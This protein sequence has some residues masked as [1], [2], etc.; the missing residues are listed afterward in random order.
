M[1]FATTGEGSTVWRRTQ[2][3]CSHLLSP[4]CLLSD[5]GQLQFEVGR[6]GQGMGDS[7]DIAPHIDGATLVATTG[8]VKPI[9]EPNVVV[10]ARQN[11]GQEL[12]LYNEI[13]P[14]RAK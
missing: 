12:L 9:S 1:Q 14:G 8:R 2:I 13:L 5:A 4:I 6:T 11:S 10:Q 3:M 7:S